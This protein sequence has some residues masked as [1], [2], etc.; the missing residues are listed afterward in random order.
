MS[1]QPPFP[2]A[3][4]ALAI[5]AGVLGALALVGWVA[6]VRW[7]RSFGASSVEIKANG[8]ICML[9]LAAAALPVSSLRARWAA[10]LAAALAGAIAFTVL[11]E[12]TVHASFGIDELLFQDPTSAGTPGRISVPGASAFVLLALSLVLVAARRLWLVGQA[13]AAGASAV[14]VASLVGQAYGSDGF[15]GI[16]SGN[17]MAA[18]QALAVIALATSVVL[19]EPNRGVVGLLRASGP[20]GRVV[21]YLV[22]A[23]IVVPFTVGLVLDRGVDLARPVENAIFTLTA[24]ILAVSFVVAAAWWLERVDVE[25]R[26]AYGEEVRLAA[27]ESAARERAR[28]EGRRRRQAEALDAMSAAM[29]GAA[30]RRHVAAV[31]ADRLRRLAGAERAQAYLLDLASGFLR[32]TTGSAEPGAPQEIPLGSDDPVAVATR[33][34]TPA[35]PGHQPGG[36]VPVALLPLISGEDPV[37]LV[38]LELTGSGRLDRDTRGLLL[39]GASR[40]ALALDRAGLHEGERLARQDAERARGRA[41]FLADAT[42]ALQEDL[43]LDR[44]LERLLALCVPT[45]ADFGMVEAFGSEGEDG[46]RAARHTDPGLEQVLRRLADVMPPRGRRSGLAALVDPGPPAVV[47]LGRE[48]RARLLADPQTRGLIEALAPNAMLVIPLVARGTEVGVLTLAA[49][50][51][52][53]ALGSED[54]RFVEALAGRTALAI[55]NARAFHEQR[56][57]AR[58][59]QAGLLAG[60]A[61]DVPDL[62]IATRYQPASDE[63]EVGG[64]WFDLVVR[65]D[66]QAVAMVG[67]VV[68]R[69]LEAAATMGRLRSAASGLA[70][71]CPGPS[72]LLDQLDRIADATPAAYLTTIACAYIDPPAADVRYAC[73]GHPPP[74]LLDPA[75]AACFLQGGRS[76][77]L[78]GLEPGQRPEDRMEFPPGATL[79]LYTDGLVERRGYALDDRL[80]LLAEAAAAETSGGVQDLA[81]RVLERMVGGAARPDDVAVLCVAFD[82]ADSTVFAQRYPAHPQHLADARNDLRRWLRELGCREDEMYDI[83][84]AAGEALANAVEHAYAGDQ[85]GDLA[86]ELRDVDGELRVQLRDFGRWRDPPAPGPRGRG[87]PIMRQVM[88]DVSLHSDAAGTIVTLRKRVP[89]RV[90][91]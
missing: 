73:A 1:A 87:I 72:E 79:I 75:G 55:E 8:A 67:D 81:D 43:D 32:L 37:G 46:I 28:T 31:G 19:A 51:P 78:I 86:M 20:G 21:R 5:L 70:L 23:S 25:R 80:D 74:L 59:L 12:Y 41:V 50:S 53:R 9:L 63:L 65:Q 88:D 14:A 24:M 29:A 54:L 38:R 22:P 64:D 15:L 7:L 27:E 89:V 90:G 68:G 26:R 18:Q 42:A 45:L 35:F 52:G 82:P 66:G 33:L 91:A 16:G 62:A 58:R 85:A 11:I 56:T 57:I 76:A 40:C 44:R 47:T 2:R 39:A 6:D 3:R 69:G 49:S 10:G 61:T 13:A 36:E 77:P 30:T 17:A 60:A 48:D 4:A 83:V 71:V 84:L 34:A